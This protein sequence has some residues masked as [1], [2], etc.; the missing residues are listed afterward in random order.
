MGETEGK[1]V[2]KM[3]KIQEKVCVFFGKIFFI[4]RHDMKRL[5]MNPIAAILAAGLMV[6]PSLYAWFNIEASWDPYGNTGN[7]KVAVANCD[8]GYSLKGMTVNVGNSIV[9]SL[10]GN[11]EIGWL[12][13]DET[14]AV[15][16]VES[17]AYYAAIVI[18][19]DFSRDMMSILTPDMV[20]PD[21]KYYVNEKT[22]A[23]ERIVYQ[24]GHHSALRY[25][26][27]SV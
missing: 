26:S 5:F 13:M 20:R 17:G 15:E 24:S 2:S 3:G 6:L 27:E 1:R 4:F 8:E 12:F 21:L 18:P 19:E 7:L 11:D 9:D 23:G 25:D 16:G 22:A 14:D 10:A